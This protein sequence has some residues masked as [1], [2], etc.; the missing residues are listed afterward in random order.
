[1]PLPETEQQ[2]PNKATYIYNIYIIYIYIYHT[3]YNTKADIYIYIY[4]TKDDPRTLLNK[5]SEIV[6]K[7]RHRNTFTLKHFC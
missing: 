1:M 3:K 7:C 2:C 4:N 5:I 6:W